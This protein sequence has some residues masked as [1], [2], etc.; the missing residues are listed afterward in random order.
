[1][2]STAMRVPTNVP[3]ALVSFC[4]QLPAAVSST[5]LSAVSSQ[6]F[7]LHGR[8]SMVP[9]KVVLPADPDSAPSMQSTSPTRQPVPFT[10]AAVCDT[11]A[12]Q[13]PVTGPSAGSA[14]CQLPAQTPA[15]SGAVRP[16]PGL[17]ESPP[18]PHPPSRL[19]VNRAIAR[20]GYWHLMAAPLASRQ[21]DCGC[22]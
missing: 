18:P 20:T 10:P 15:R 14:P 17:S 12:C 13:N 7:R 11:V 4:V 3:C 21:P 19:A 5:E 6:V 9:V 22:L 1:P 2:P 16:P 8:R